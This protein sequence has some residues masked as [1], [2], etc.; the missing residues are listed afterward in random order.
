M[1]ACNNRGC[2]ILRLSVSLL[3]F[4]SLLLLAAWAFANGTPDW[5]TQAGLIFIGTT[6]VCAINFCY[7]V[8][9]GKRFSSQPVTSAG[10]ADALA[11]MGE[12]QG[13][14][15]DALRSS[16]MQALYDLARPRG[17][18]SAERL[19]E[20]ARLLRDRGEYVRT[21]NALADFPVA[22]EILYLAG[23]GNALVDID[24]M[25]RLEGLLAFIHARESEAVSLE[26]MEF[27]DVRLD[28]LYTD[29]AFDLSHDSPHV[30]SA[31]SHA[32]ITHLPHIDY[33]DVVKAT[34]RIVPIEQI[35]SLPL[36]ERRALFARVRNIIENGVNQPNASQI[37]EIK[38]WVS[39]NVR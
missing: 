16:S 5:T 1:L 39:D 14:A 28:D 34:L 26:A 32:T 19:E 20:A 30:D 27:V 12:T 3:N 7:L 24:A 11:A 10:Y 13:A 25:I 23:D 6:F 4:C 21:L 37:E 18:L 38:A 2:E 17:S 9:G 15:R 35:S 33:E 8:F 22:R 36:A 31:S 29:A